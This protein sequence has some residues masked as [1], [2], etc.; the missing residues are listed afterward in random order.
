MWVC[1]SKDPSAKEG[2]TLQRINTLNWATVSTDL[3]V[4]LDKFLS[5]CDQDME[6]K[7]C[8]CPANQYEHLKTT[9]LL[10]ALKFSS[11]SSFLGDFWEFGESD[12]FC[13]PPHPCYCHLR[14]RPAQ[15]FRE[16]FHIT[17][18]WVLDAIGSALMS[19]YVMSSS[20]LTCCGQT[21]HQ[22][23]RVLTSLFYGGPSCSL[24]FLFCL[25]AGG[26]GTAAAFYWSRWCSWEFPVMLH[27]TASGF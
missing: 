8:P 7:C 6:R 12:S 11:F 25:G 23:A 17:E 20:F 10:P 14:E 1:L 24:L 26:R 15:F 9:L 22:K 19:G 3:R 27:R 2:C 5:S 4:Q 16:V 13:P 21:P 18:P